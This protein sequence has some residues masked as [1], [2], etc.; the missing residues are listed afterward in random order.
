[1]KSAAEYQRDRDREARRRNNL[2]PRPEDG[3]WCTAPLPGTARFKPTF[4][5]SKRHSAAKRLP[6]CEGA[7]AATA[8][9]HRQARERKKAG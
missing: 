1:M 9:A 3:C 4:M 5:Y 6:S 2:D 8:W 7:R